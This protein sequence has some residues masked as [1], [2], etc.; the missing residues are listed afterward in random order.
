MYYNHVII[1][2]PIQTSI[3]FVFCYTI[4][5]ENLENISKSKVCVLKNLKTQTLGFENFSKRKL[6]VLKSFP[7]N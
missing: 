6:Y 4:V 7:K 2:D 5:S 1:F 3:I